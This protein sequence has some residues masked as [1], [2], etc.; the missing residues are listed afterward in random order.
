M[1]S[2]AAPPAAGSSKPLALTVAIMAYNE[3]G[4][5]EQ[6]VR[7]TLDAVGPLAAPL[8]VLIIDDGST[9][10][11]GELARELARRFAAVRVIHHAPN[12][13]LG[14][15]YRTAFAQAAL[16]WLAFLPADGEIP[17][18]CLP[19]LLEH[20]HDADL[21]L[22]YLPRSPAPLSARLLSRA[23]RWLLRALV[24]PIPRFQGAWAVRT[25]VLREVPLVSV[26]RGWMIVMELL[27]RAQRSGYR[28]RS[29]PTVLAPRLAGSSKARTFANVV[30]NLEQTLVLAKALRG[31][32]T[33]ASRQ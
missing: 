16:D 1:S 27:A 25:Q 14:A 10:G 17:P 29:V 33:R 8:D 9:D 13:G 21:C 20:A 24:G 22:G 19:S 28:L 18:E 15:V 4:S 3:V 5:L 11:T 6:V 23:E 7:R 12:G 26:G 30:A 31:K 32:D 2:A